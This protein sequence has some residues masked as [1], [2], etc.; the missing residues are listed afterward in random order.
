MRTSWFAFWPCLLLSVVSHCALAVFL[1]GEQETAVRKTS[2]VIG[3]TML[4][5]TERLQRVPELPELPSA[6]AERVQPPKVLATDRPQLL[7][8]AEV[9][10]LK[11]DLVLRDAV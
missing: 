7:S 11:S 1:W 6:E 3:I 9:Q 5:S 10:P 8:V 2:V 4:D